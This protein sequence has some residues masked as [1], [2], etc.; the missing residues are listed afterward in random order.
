MSQ[1]SIATRVLRLLRI[2]NDFEK[3]TIRVPAFQRDFEWDY[4]KKVQLFES[5]LKGLPIG[6]IFLWRPD[7]IDNENYRL[8]ESN[9]I[10]GYNLPERAIDYYYVLDGLQRLSTLFGCLI[11]EKQTLLKKDQ[12]L[13]S[14]QGFNLIYNLET[15]KIEKGK[16]NLQL[17]E[18]ELYKFVDHNSYAEF[19]DNMQKENLS[20]EKKQIFRDR[21]VHFQ[22]QITSFDLPIVELSGA[23]INEAVE[24]FDKL[25]STGAK[26]TSEWKLNA[27][28]F[29]IEQ[30]FR[31]GNE[32]DELLI[33][34]KEYNFDSLDRKVIFNS[35]VNSFGIVF[36]DKSSEN[37][38][39]KIEKLANDPSFIQNTR[40]TIRS[41][42]KSVDFL[43]KELKVFN[44]K[45]LPYN[46]QLIFITDFFNKVENPSPIQ[47]KT[48]KEW[49]WVTTYSNY[50]TIYNLS[51]QRKAYDKF[52]N[53]IYKNDNPIYLDTLNKNFNTESFPSKI[54]MGSVRGKALALFMIN[55]LIN[56]NV[57]LSKVTL[58]VENVTNIKI[59]KL[60]KDYNSSE[61]TIYVIE[62]YNLID[63]FPKSVKDV[64]FMLLMENKG[65]YSEYFI[66]DEMRE[67]Y[68]KGN[69]KNVLESRK[70]LIMKEERKFVE[71]LD[72]YYTDPFLP[73]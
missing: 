50:F 58:N 46:S 65:K 14:Q 32:I 55:F 1:L 53:F 12:K 29:N 21:Y 40:N 38:N 17:C 69:I 60:F 70:E 59:Y 2:I 31:L 43:H 23:G 57:F 72:I 56:E 48:L 66:T 42:K 4:S 73:W 15:N 34:L 49:L 67:V 51:K 41:I 27:L 63:N 20:T 9:S 35:I 13:W 37:D 44:S 39:K 45:L 22:R 30:N 33:D 7:F 18:V 16:K 26:V 5:I 47:L 28:S 61:N 11:D 71:S 54:S 68:A 52:Q 24:I 19:I 10:G 64:S 8:F 25:N 62:E 3:G 6:T 36:F